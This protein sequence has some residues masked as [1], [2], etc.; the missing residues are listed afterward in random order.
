MIV[1]DDIAF[2]VRSHE[3]LPFGTQSGNVAIPFPYW[4][5]AK[6]VDSKV[7][8]DVESVVLPMGE[9]RRLPHRVAP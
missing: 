2:D 8:G 5:R 1:E 3:T 6:T 9:Q 4:M 7:A